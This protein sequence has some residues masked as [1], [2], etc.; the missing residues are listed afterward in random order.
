M[1]LAMLVVIVLCG[2]IVTGPSGFVEY[3]K[4]IR[5]YERQG[6][7][8]RGREADHPHLDLSERKAAAL[9]VNGKACY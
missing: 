7:Q 5:M 9:P 1:F 6:E 3:N 8:R 2:G 4:Y